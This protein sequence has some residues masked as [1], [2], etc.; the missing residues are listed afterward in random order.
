MEGGLAHFVASDAHDPLKRPPHLLEAFR[1]VS[2][3]VGAAR[4]ADLFTYNPLALLNDEL[5]P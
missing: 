5:I 1:R 4:A 3:L 2:E